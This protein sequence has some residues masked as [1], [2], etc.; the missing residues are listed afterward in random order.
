MVN[1]AYN[2]LL[3]THTTGKNYD[4]SYIEIRQVS[5]FCLSGTIHFDGIE[6]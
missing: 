2:D 3:N 6:P 4:N 1:K 5:V